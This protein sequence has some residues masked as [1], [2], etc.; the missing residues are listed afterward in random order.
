MKVLNYIL[1]GILALSV[2]SCGNDWLDLESS[3]EIPSEGSLV[4]LTDFQYSLNGIYSAMQN[5]DGYTGRIVYYGD[6]TADDVQAASATKRTGSYYLLKYTKDNAPSSLWKIPY[7]LIRNANIIL[8]EID[9]IPETEENKAER[10][11][12]I[13]QALTLRALALFDLTRI[14]GY[15]YAKD[16]GAS[17]GACI[18]EDVRTIDSKPA[19]N[20][21]AECY[22]A[23]IKDLNNAIP[24]LSPDF[25]F[26]KL[27]RWGAMLLLSRAYLYKGDNENA[28]KVAEEAIAGAE[29]KK[30]RLWDNEKYPTAWADERSASDPGE[31][32]FEIVNTTVDS[33]GKESMG[34]LCWRSGY[35]D[36]ILT[37]SFFGL[38][39][40]DPDDVRNKVYELYKAK[41]YINKYQPQKNEN[42]A[43]ANIPLLRLSELYLNA[44]EAAVKL[45]NNAKAIEY[46]EPIVERAN[47]EKTV[48]GETISL[49][50]V[51]N[52]RRKELFGEGHRLYDALRNNQTIERKDVK[53]DAV[54]STKHLSMPDE[55]KK[56]D[57]N[58]YRVVLPIP[59]FEID[60]NPNIAAQQNP[61]Y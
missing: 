56:F 49:E 44:A 6:V 35:S 54:S 57:W 20:T 60:T 7:Q 36:M 15:P 31:V 14:Y 39:S 32:L 42:Q 61:G 51:L 37:S 19:R 23:V 27:N 10:S 48:Q 43:D 8:E 1:S 21:V 17:L 4:N 47:P 16:N 33:P 12:I 29:K 55:A 46:L 34:Y 58:Y 28:L 45:G 2:T 30:Y 5:S 40:E 18:V 52:E 38:L 13:G 50:R 59:K 41:A 22:D 9:N 26:G 53:I 3:T 24:Q 25:N 11:D